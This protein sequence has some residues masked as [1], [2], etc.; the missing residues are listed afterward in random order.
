MMQ[1]IDRRLNGRHKS[2]LNRQRFIGRYKDQIKNAIAEAIAQRSIT[3]VVS[4]GRVS[5]PRRHIGEPEFQFG[6]GGWRHSVHPGNREFAAGD[7]IDRPAAK[8]AAVRPAMAQ[9]ARIRLPS[10]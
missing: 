10:N 8:A 7:Q 6:A 3:D 5:I 2:A 1:L 9:K 4:G